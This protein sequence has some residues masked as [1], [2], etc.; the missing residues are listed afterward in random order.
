M[1]KFYVHIGP[2]HK[3][4]FLILS[5]VYWLFYDNCKVVR[6]EVLNL[7]LDNTTMATDDTFKGRLQWQITCAFYQLDV[8]I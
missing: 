7:P 6:F 3:N 2:S 1:V 8:F 5:H 4:S